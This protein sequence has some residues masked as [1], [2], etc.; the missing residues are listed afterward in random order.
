MN[1]HL[2]K[3]SD[4]YQQAYNSWKEFYRILGHSASRKAGK[5]KNNRIAGSNSIRDALELEKKALTYVNNALDVE[6]RYGSN[7]ITNICS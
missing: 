2:L 6:C 5:D 7:Q 4:Y 3:A 1:E